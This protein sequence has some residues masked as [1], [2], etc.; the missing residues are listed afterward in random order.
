MKRR[1]ADILDRIPE[2]P[3]WFDEHAVPRFCAFAPDRI[4]DIYAEETALVEIACQS[5]DHR[6]P[7]AFSL[8]RMEKLLHKAR[9]LEERVRERS[10]G[11]GDPPNIECCPAGPTMTA[12]AVRVIE[13]WSKKSFDW[14][15]RPELEIS[16]EEPEQEDEA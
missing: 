5:C 11:F 9:P 14:K 12:D 10:I 2:E 13:F 6:F 7:V 3:Q 16:L 8:G 4:A 15:R 1:Y